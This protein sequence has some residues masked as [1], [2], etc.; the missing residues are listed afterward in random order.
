MRAAGLLAG[1]IGV[2]LV[3]CAQAPVGTPPAPPPG[4]P[5]PSGSASATAGFPPPTA[6]GSAS[7]TPTASA[8][9]AGTCDAL[10]RGLDLKAAAGELVMVGVTGSLDAAEQNAIQGSQIGSVILMG[11]STAGVSGTKQ[12]TDA[13]RRVGGPHGVLIGVDQEGGNVTRLKGSGFSEMPSAAQQAKLSDA[14]LQAKA[15]GWA[16]EMVQAGINIDFAPVADVVPASKQRTNEPI[17]KLGRGYGSDPAAVSDKVAAV[18]KGFQGAGLGATVKHFPNLGQVTGNTDFASKV[19]DDVTT[20]DDGALAP[21]RAA[22]KADAA[23]IMVATAYYSKIDG[24]EPA[25]FSPKVVGIVR[26]LGFTGVITSDDLGVAKAVASVPPKQ[27]AVKFVEAGGD[28]A[29]SV[30]PAAATAMVA[31]LVEAGEKDPALAQRIKE[32][33]GRVMTLKGRLGV[34][35]CKS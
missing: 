34:T 15:A 11:S 5:T 9:P 18:V 12:R 10:G 17:G 20:A 33:A 22:I 32:S 23:S 2:A 6:S 29:I 3:G 16:R 27:R 35:S 24:T 25:A 21:Y 26:Q 4:T 31:G 1:L 7:G 13:V 28:L 8:P 14:A 30:D 19:V